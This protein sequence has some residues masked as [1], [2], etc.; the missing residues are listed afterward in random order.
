MHR[1]EFR[2]SEEL[3]QF[4]LMIKC[5][6]FD[7][8]GVLVRIRPTWDYAIVVCGIKRYREMKEMEHRRDIAV[9]KLGILG[10][11]Q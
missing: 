2:L 11:I 9:D 6:C 1:G 10:G 4:S 5:V 8:G 3:G 7:L